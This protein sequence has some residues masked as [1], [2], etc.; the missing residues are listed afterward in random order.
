MKAD[1]EGG[2]PLDIS[3]QKLDRNGFVSKQMFGNNYFIPPCL[4][5]GFFSPSNQSKPS[6]SSAGSKEVIS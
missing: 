1:R 4:Y 5:Y 2:R 3:I 6:T